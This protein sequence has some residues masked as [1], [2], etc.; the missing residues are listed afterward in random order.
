M[1]IQFVVAAALAHGRVDDA[2]LRDFGA[3]G[4]AARLARRVRLEN[5]AGFA[6][7]YPQ[8]QG[9]EVVVTTKGGRGAA[10]RLV[11]LEPL[12]PAGVRSR[13]RAAL[14]RLLDDERAQRIEREIDAIVDCQDICRMVRLLA[15]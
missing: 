2:V 13:T 12:A 1:S 11:E 5:D 6:G 15:R 4:E 14:A 7:G 9:A 10:S 8:R 3:D